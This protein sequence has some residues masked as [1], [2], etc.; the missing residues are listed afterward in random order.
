MSFTRAYAELEPT[1]AQVDAL[2]GKTL[3]EF[4]APW[5]GHCIA[6]QPA[7]EAALSAREDVVHLKIEDG[8]GRPLGRSFRIKL[9]PTLIVL[10]DGVEV[11]RVV[12]PVTV[13][14]KW[15]ACWRRPEGG[16]TAGRKHRPRPLDNVPQAAH[17][18]SPPR[19][20]Q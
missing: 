20:S 19:S 17:R 5:C 10:R 6:A 11:G 3:L 13:D 8:R 9:W 7:I 2:V 14:E 4:G 1:H 16:G 18:R 12:R 15:N